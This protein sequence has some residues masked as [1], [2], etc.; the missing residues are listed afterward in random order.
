M[1]QASEGTPSKKELMFQLACDKG[2]VEPRDTL[3][4]V[5]R[6]EM[7]ANGKLAEDYKQTK[8]NEAKAKFRLEWARHWHRP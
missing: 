2:G 1:P 3:G 5:F 6:R 7:Q 8:G 4:T